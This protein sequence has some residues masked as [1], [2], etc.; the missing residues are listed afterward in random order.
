M[1]KW[2]IVFSHKN[3]HSHRH[4]CVLEY[5]DCDRNLIERKALDWPAPCQ[6]YQVQQVNVACHGAARGND[7][8]KGESLENNKWDKKLA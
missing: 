7:I 5:I 2:Q 6:P 8:I 1:N 3:T 4:I